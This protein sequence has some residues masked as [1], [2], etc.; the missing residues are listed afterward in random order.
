[1][2]EVQYYLTL[3]AGGSGGRAV[4]IYELARVELYEQLSSI[5][6]AA[7]YT[8]SNTTSCFVELK[9]LEELVGCFKT[10]SNINASEVKDKK[11]SYAEVLM[12]NELYRW[13]LREYRYLVPEEI[14]DSLHSLQ[15]QLE[16]MDSHGDV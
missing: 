8:R 13:M 6:D 3:R 12:K 14:P 16:R 10:Y 7:W 9:N 11:G 15:Q 2:G 1:M 5:G 4:I